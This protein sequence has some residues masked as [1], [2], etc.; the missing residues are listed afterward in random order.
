[1]L[2]YLITSDTGGK[3]PCFPYTISKKVNFQLYYIVYYSKLPEPFCI[4]Y[5]VRRGREC[6]EE[7]F[8]GGG[9]KHKGGS[10]DMMPYS[11]VQYHETLKCS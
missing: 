7:V 3:K 11:N 9:S 4:H 6:K 1:M 8:A 2:I 5:S 10:Y